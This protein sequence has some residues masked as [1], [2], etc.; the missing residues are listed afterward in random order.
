MKSLKSI[1]YGISLMLPIFTCL[2][3]CWQTVGAD[4]QCNDT[5]CMGDEILEAATLMTEASCD[6]AAI[7]HSDQSGFFSA[8]VTAQLEDSCTRSR[9]WVKADHRRSDFVKSGK[10]NKPDCYIV[11]REGD[12]IGNDDGICTRDE[13]GKK[14]GEFGC[15]EDE[16][17]GNE[18]CEIVREGKG[19][20]VW[21]KCF[22]ICDETDDSLA[23]EDISTMKHMAGALLDAAEA[24]DET[25]SQLVNRLETLE[26]LQALTV[27]SNEIDP[28]DSCLTAST[29]KVGNLSYP[30]GARSNDFSELRGAI[31]AV[32]V[33]EG[34]A[35]ACTDAMDTT[36]FGWDL[37][38]VC[39]PVHLGMTAAAI[40]AEMWELLDDAITGTR[41]DN[42]SLCLEQL[43]SKLN[44]MD[45][46]LDLIMDYLNMPPGRR[47]EFPI[48]P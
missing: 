7:A 46:K 14:P 12:G 16:G 30:D 47:P 32:R 3:M 18:I 20:K 34:A 1:R 43:G 23:V 21:E 44:A 19:K 39:I 41:V 40:I 42:M 10:R 37:P 36:V 24:L 29:A 31:A 25:N 8:A 28:N 27:E 35:N 5:E 48:K 22:E 2:L 26:S 45:E 9:N 17:N 33:L 4:P 15:L 6:S 38:A 11:E 13:K